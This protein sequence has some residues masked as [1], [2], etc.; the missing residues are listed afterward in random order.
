MVSFCYNYLSTVCAKSFSLDFR[1]RCL[2]TPEIEGDRASTTTQPS[3]ATTPNPLIP[4]PLLREWAKEELSRHSWQDALVASSTVSIS[5]RFDI[6]CGL[7]TP[8][9]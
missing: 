6:G 8:G 2:S 7:N 5:F 9:L 1:Q 3:D 4:P